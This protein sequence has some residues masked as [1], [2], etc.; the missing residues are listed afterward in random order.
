MDIGGCKFTFATENVY[1]ASKTFQLHLSVSC[2]NNCWLHHS[3]HWEEAF[4]RWEL[5]KHSHLL[6]EKQRKQMAPTTYILWSMPSPVTLLIS[7]NICNTDNYYL[8]EWI[9][10]FSKIWESKIMI[11]KHH[12]YCHDEGWTWHWEKW[13]I[14]QE[15]EMSNLN[16]ILQSQKYNNF[17]TWAI[18][19]HNIKLVGTFSKR[20]RQIYVVITNT[21]IHLINWK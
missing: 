12:H 20:K 15:C 13:E 8:T 2:W 5:V 6:R 3:L 10:I 21:I 11:D 14:G 1:V 9:V 4:S 7:P 18:S 19:P 16:K 17:H